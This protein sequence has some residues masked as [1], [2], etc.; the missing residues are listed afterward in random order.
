M[1]YFKLILILC[2][3]L[4]FYQ[5]VIEDNLEIAYEYLIYVIIMMSLVFFI[6]P[7]V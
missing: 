6:E 5:S 7:V 1:F 3:L 4:C 2:S